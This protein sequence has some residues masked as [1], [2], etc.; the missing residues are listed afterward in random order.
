MNKTIRTRLDKLILAIDGL[1]LKD[2]KS[3]ISK[4]M[5][6]LKDVYSINY[7]TK[8]STIYKKELGL[9]DERLQRSATVGKIEL[10]KRKANQKKGLIKRASNKKK[11]INLPIM[12]EVAKEL[13]CSDR[14]T[15][16]AS[17]LALL[18]GRRITEILKTGNFTNYKR[19]KYMLNFDGQLKKKGENER[20]PLYALF[21]TAKDCKIALGRI[22]L[23]L[24]TKK[25]TNEDVSRKYNKAVNS[26]VML[27]FSPFIGRCSAHDLRAV[28][29]A[30]CSR[31]YRPIEIDENVFFSGLLGHNSDD[32]ETA[33]SYKKYIL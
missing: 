3:A 30:V 14:Y 1:N 4:E 23:I 8:V 26:R 2:S 21:N 32:I 6:H 20:Y 24:D 19:S 11:V 22:R 33:N 27:H 15:D 9:I 7:A 25:M 18:T 16:I 31:E 5:Q 10:R 12:I 13:L 28:Y 17:G 29:A